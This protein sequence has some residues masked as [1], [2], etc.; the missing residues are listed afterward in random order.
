MRLTRRLVFA[1]IV[2]G[3]ALGTAGAASADVRVSVPPSPIAP[4]ELTFRVQQPAPADVLVL[5]GVAPGPP[6]VVVLPPSPV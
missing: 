1:A 2:C 6:T 5:F 4:P 3:A